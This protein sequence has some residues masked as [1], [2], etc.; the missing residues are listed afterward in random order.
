MCQQ[1]A[2]YMKIVSEKLIY[3]DCVHLTPHVG[4][5]SVDVNT[6]AVNIFTLFTCR[7]TIRPPETV[8]WIGRFFSGVLCI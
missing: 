3:R 6:M 8:V 7:S 5:V 4:E 2:A 1:A